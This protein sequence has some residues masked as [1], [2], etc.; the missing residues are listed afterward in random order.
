MRILE[1]FKAGNKDLAEFWINFKGQF[2][3][4][5]YFAVRDIDGTYRGVIEMSQDV[6]HV[7]ELEG[8]QRLL[9]WE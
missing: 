2:I 1:E 5:Q 9:D 3:H 7:R 4:I 8:E 6:T